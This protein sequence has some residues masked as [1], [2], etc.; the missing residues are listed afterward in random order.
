MSNGIIER[1]CANK[2]LVK[3]AAQRQRYSDGKKLMTIQIILSI[4]VVGIFAVVGLI[5]K[6]SEPWISV[7]LPY[8][9][10]SITILNLVFF[11]AKISKIKEEASTIQE[12]FDCNVLKITWNGFKADWPQYEDIKGHADKIIKTNADYGKNKLN[13]WYINP[14]EEKNNKYHFDD[15]PLPISRLICQRMNCWWDHSLGKGFITLI[16]I[17]TVLLIVILVIYL[18]YSGIALSQFCNGLLF[19]ALP[20]I[21]ITIRYI[22][23]H[24]KANKKLNR[25]ENKANTIWKQLVSSKTLDM[26][27]ESRQLQD[28]IFDSRKT[29][30]LIPDWYYNY[31][32]IPYETKSYYSIEQM[33]KEYNQGK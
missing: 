26:A 20:A 32:R 24:L 18:F 13:N 16:F 14:E 30:Q 10:F 8:Y 31:L 33:V 17:L 5:Y 19:P 4:V 7:I 28:E 29:R 15:L 11:D 27:I 2:N 6:D 1:Q 3:L 9:G 21:V 12:D 23:D 25:L 22:Q